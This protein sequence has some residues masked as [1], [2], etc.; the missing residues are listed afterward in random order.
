MDGVISTERVE[1]RAGNQHFVDVTISVPRSA[2]F[3]QCTPFPTPSSIASQKLFRGRDGHMNRAPPWRNLF[4]RI[5]VSRAARPLIH[6]LS[7]HHL[8]GRLFI[9]LH[10]K[11]PSN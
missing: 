3:E 9:E 7:A 1:S 2:S 11:C 8:D 6:E 4:D 10:L 5:R